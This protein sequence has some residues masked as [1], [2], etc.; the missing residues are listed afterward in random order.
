MTCYTFID[1]DLIV[2][3]YINVIYSTLNVFNLSLLSSKKFS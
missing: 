1:I 3:N 2:F